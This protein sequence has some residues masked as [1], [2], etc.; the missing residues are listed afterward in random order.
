MVSSARMTATV[1]RLSLHRCFQHLAWGY[2]AVTQIP[3]FP[4]PFG[5]CVSYRSCKFCII[6]VIFNTVR[7]GLDSQDVGGQIHLQIL[8]T[9]SAHQCTGT[10]KQ[11]LLRQAL[12]R[13]NGHHAAESLRP[14]TLHWSVLRTK[15][16]QAPGA[17]SLFT[18][19]LPKPLTNEPEA[20]SP[21]STQP[22]RYEL[23]LGPGKW[24]SSQHS[25]DHVR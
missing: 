10:C 6:L 9:N 15:L 12:K 23:A 11:Q 13:A 24:L 3:L 25:L 16:T 8:A 4:L 20:E 7:H 17:Q 1:T 2:L 18:S 19:N 14:R 22:I 21:M 5:A